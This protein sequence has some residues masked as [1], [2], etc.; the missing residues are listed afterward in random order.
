MS[1]QNQP[2]RKSLKDEI[3]K[4]KTQ[5]V[6][7]QI[8]ESRYASQMA[9]PAPRKTGQLTPPEESQQTST[10]APSPQPKGTGSLEQ[11]KATGPLVPPIPKP[12]T[13]PLASPVPTPK[14]RQ[15]GPLAPRAPD[16]ISRIRQ[17]L[18][19]EAVQER[20]RSR[21]FQIA[22][23]AGLLIIVVSLATF[24]LA[25]SVG[26]QALPTPIQLP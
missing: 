23:I 24:S 7:H 14:P 15:T 5:D 10:P 19:T 8:E 2:P 17:T 21:P 1:D 25:G 20:L 12:N 11:R 6:A 26:Q 3:Q 9:T 4:R 22:I 16:E 18:T 13:G